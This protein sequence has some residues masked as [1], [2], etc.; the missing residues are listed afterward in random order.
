[1]DE[2]ELVMSFTEERALITLGWV[3]CPPV[4]D[5]LSFLH[6]IYRYTPTLPS[7][8][9]GSVPEMVLTYHLVLRFHV[10]RRLA[11]ALRFPAYAPRVI[12]RGLCSV[13]YAKVWIPSSLSR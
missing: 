13:F 10:V 8:V 12:R 9:S 7:P 4:A 3:C 2:E 11:H 1:M 6:V 5:L